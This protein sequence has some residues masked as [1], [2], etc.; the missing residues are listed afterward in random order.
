MAGGVRSRGVRARRACITRGGG[1]A[2]LGQVG[3]CVPRGVACLGG[4]EGV[5]A[6][7]GVACLGACMVGRV[8]MPEGVYMPGVWEG[9][10]H[11]WGHTLSGGMHG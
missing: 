8:C 6:R 4:R 2:C 10:M 11:A 1:H 7:G 9:G 5:S 3:V